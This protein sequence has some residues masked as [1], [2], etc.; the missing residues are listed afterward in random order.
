MANLKDN[1]CF[2]GETLSAKFAAPPNT[3]A[4]TLRFAVGGKI[5]EV[6]GVADNGL[7]STT[8]TTNVAGRANWVVYAT[9]GDEVKAIESGR[10]YVR[11]MVSRYTEVIEA[12]EQALIDWAENPNKSITVGELNITYKDRDDLLGILAHYRQLELADL[13]GATFTGGFRMMGVH[14]R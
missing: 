14:F 4:V 3:A 1:T 8:L 10:I 12:I 11:P 9:V 5:T 13:E 2:I 7:W 6:S